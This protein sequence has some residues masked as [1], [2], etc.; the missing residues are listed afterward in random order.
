MNKR[1]TILSVPVDTYSSDEFMKRIARTLNDSK[2]KTIFAVNAEKVM[3]ARKDT[4]LFQALVEADFLLPDGIGA[5]IGVRLKYSEKIQRTTGFGMMGKIL[6]MAAEGGQ[7]VFFFGAKP[8]I[9]RRASKKAKELHPSLNLVG[10]QH[11]HIRE[12]EYDDLVNSINASHADILFV[13]LGSPKQEKWIYRYRKSLKV[14]I[15]MGVGG[16][17]DVLAGKMVIA[18]RWIQGAGLE[19]LYRMLREPRRLKRQMVLPRFVM[20]IVRDKIFS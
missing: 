19:W 9:N 17:F 7:R 1:I 5:V 12:E 3:H 13:G 11:G 2:L 10:I 15:C 6:D 14:K 16:S 18:P 4:E 20:D 8:E